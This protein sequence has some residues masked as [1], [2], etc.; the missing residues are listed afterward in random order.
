[1]S[2]KNLARTVIEG[3][4]ARSNKKERWYSNRAHRRSVRIFVEKEPPE[5]AAP[6]RRKRVYRGFYDKLGPARRWLDQQV[7]ERWDDV[8]SVLFARFDA[9]TL[10]GRHV[11]YGHL[12]EWVKD[13]PQDSHHARFQVDAVGRLEPLPRRRS[14]RAPPCQE[15][16]AKG[17][18]AWAGGRRVRALGTKLFWLVPVPKETGRPPEAKKANRTKEQRLADELIRYRQDRALTKV[19]MER[20]GALCR[21]AR[22]RLLL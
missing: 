17:A 1:L 22:E 18:D 21:C 20:F 10:A 12:L 6:P 7:G 19:E 2:T 3:G 14:G 4:R 5:D 13:G 16:D 9:R 8:R 11:L 15:R